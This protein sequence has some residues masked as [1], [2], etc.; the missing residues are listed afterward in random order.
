MQ[1]R[2]K[3]HPLT[4]DQITHL[5][6]RTQTCNLA[7]LNPDGTPYCTPIH[8]IYWGGAIYFHGLP[9]GQKLGNIARDSRV[10]ISAYEMEGLLL[11][12]GEKPCDTNTK[13]ESVIISGIAKRLE[14]Q[15]EKRNV[16]TKIVE[17]YTPHLANKE[18]PDNMV[19]GTA[20]IRVDLAEITGKYYA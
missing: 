14:D 7:T 8:F 18:L 12:P 11:D 10:G 3:T 15:N 2:M 5:L 20:V 1:Y 13:Y 6:E 9:I 17:K 4:E 19:K 16:L